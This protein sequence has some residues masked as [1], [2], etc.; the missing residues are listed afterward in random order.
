MLV[1]IF[2]GATCKFIDY[3]CR[4][5]SKLPKFLEILI[6][7]MCTVCFKF[8]FLTKIDQ[9]LLNHYFLNLSISDKI[10]ESGWYVLVQLVSEIYGTEKK[11][12]GK[13][14]PHQESLFLCGSN[15]VKDDPK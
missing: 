11:K 4:N 6:T 14:G 8:T 12:K 7:L 10:Y 9:L 13:N 15:H 3:K 2:T 5:S 1:M